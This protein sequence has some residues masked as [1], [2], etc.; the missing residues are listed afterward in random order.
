M[1]KTTSFRNSKCPIEY[2]GQK[3]KNYPTLMQIGIS[4]F[5][6]LLITNLLLYFS[7][8]RWRIQYGERNIKIIQCLSKLV[9]RDSAFLEVIYV[10]SYD[11]PVISEYKDSYKSRFIQIGYLFNSS[12]ARMDP[13]F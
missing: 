11:E 6:K 13:L 4:S 2:G 9:R 3:A 12:I 5:L 1:N 10:K 8:L 7:N